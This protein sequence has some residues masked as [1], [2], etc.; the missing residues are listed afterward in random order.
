MCK[1]RIILSLLALSV[2]AGCAR[3]QAQ[4]SSFSTLTMPVVNKTIAVIGYPEETNRSLEFSSYRP[5]FEQNFRTVG[6][7]IASAEKTDYIA[8]VSYGIDTGST[9][10]SLVSTPVYGQTGGGTSYTSGT[11]STSSGGYGTYSGTTYTMPTY[12]IVG[13]STSSVQSTVY[14]RRLAVD[15]V[16]ASTLEADN[17]RKVYEGR[18]TSAGSCGAMNEVIDEFIQALF[19]KFPNDSGRVAVKGKFDC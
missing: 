10:T 9:V 8:F 1:H 12:G 7:S 17:P 18:L 19:I 3:V 5:I 15:I 2:L 6:F 14:K 11:V 16:E 4:V 13:S